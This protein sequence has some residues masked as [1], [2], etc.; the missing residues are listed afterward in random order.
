MTPFG[1]PCLAPS[2]QEYPI[3]AQISESV[4]ITNWDP[5]PA[6]ERLAVTEMPTMPQYQAG[7]VQ[8][9][10]YAN[11]QTNMA[12]PAMGN[13]PAHYPQAQSMGMPC[14][15]AE[16]S[17]GYAPLVQHVSTQCPAMGDA[18]GFSSQAQHMGTQHAVMGSPLDYCA[19]G[20][21]SAMQRPVMTNFSGYNP[22]FQQ[23]DVRQVVTQGLP[24][25]QYQAIQT[26]WVP[27]QQQ[28][29]VGYQ[30]M[31]YHP[32][33]MPSS[34]LQQ[35]VTAHQPPAHSPFFPST[36]TTP[37]HQNVPMGPPLAPASGPGVTA[38]RKRGRPS[39]A[40]KA[41][42]AALQRQAMP[43]A[44]AGPS[45]AAP[46][47]ALAPP[48]TAPAPES[49]TLAPVS[50]LPTVA[51]TS[52][53]PSPSIPAA[54]PVPTQETFTFTD[55]LPFTPT[56]SPS[57]PVDTTPEPTPTREAR[58]ESTR[59]TI[60]PIVLIT[61]DFAPNNSVPPIP[62][63]IP[64]L[65]SLVAESA[66]V[67]AQAQAQ[68]TPEPVSRLSVAWTSEPSRADSEWF[69]YRMIS[70]RASEFQMATARKRRAL[71]K[72]RDIAEVWDQEE[73]RKQASTEFHQLLGY[74]EC[75]E[76]WSNINT[77]M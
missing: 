71:A 59:T 11:G 70:S 40:E 52:P 29:S 28:S 49:A 44:D 24:V 27:S 77:A 73:R 20:Q 6:M 74:M 21:Y 48:E 17:N 60:N 69:R 66:K 54:V 5:S 65:A 3:P 12:Y 36:I 64:T 13:L 76:L 18:F 55:P 46:P 47:K 68:E 39:N 37:S 75:S 10:S 14:P 30:P 42:A 2:A 57:V 45:L 62:T 38:K 32:T 33:D 50:G 23:M 8:P 34:M 31:P 41:R 67:T 25:N 72:E 1:Y 63:H 35:E 43:V 53:T 58:L 15:V 9:S 51:I 22:P 7:M 19:P 61:D 26:Q 16:P 56:P 4:P